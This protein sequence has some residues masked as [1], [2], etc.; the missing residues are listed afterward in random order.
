DPVTRLTWDNPALVA[1]A[2]AARIGLADGDLAQVSAGAKS[3]TLPVWILPGMAD[4]T[5]V[6][7]L[8]YGRQAA[9]R[10]GTAVGFDVGPLRT[11]EAPD[12]LAGVA[13][14]KA[15]GAAILAATQE[16]GSMEGR[17]LIREGT[18][19]EFKKDPSFAKEAV[20]IPELES[21]WTEK[22]YDS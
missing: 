14:A 5:I 1:P 9:G 7:T 15:G 21:M 16:H 12:L 17:P 2:T 18:L 10:I 3:L 6:L 22:K 4:G 11:R 8:G 20:E 19:A 13:L